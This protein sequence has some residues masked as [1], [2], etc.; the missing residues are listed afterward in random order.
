VP[1][2]IIG[3]NK[4]KNGA[5]GGWLVWSLLMVYCI[6]KQ[7]INNTDRK[8]LKVGLRDLHP[9]LVIINIFIHLTYYRIPSTTKKLIIELSVV[10]IGILNVDGHLLSVYIREG[11]IINVMI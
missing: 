8:R 3:L 4:I 11:D 5:M 1:I 9:M 2:G 10:G 6:I 7:K